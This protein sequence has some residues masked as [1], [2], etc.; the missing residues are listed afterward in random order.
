MAD[1]LKSGDVVQLKSGGP[2]MTVTHEMSGGAFSCV[3]FDGS[4]YKTYTFKSDLLTSAD[5]P[6]PATK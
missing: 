5:Q 6:D 4:N 3:W 1:N 2:R